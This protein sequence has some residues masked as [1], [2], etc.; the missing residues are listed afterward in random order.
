MTKKKVNLNEPL[1]DVVPFTEGVQVTYNHN[2]IVQDSDTSEYAL[3]TKNKVLMGN[4][5]IA[6]KKP[7]APIVGALINLTDTA[8]IEHNIVS[9]FN[10]SVLSESDSGYIKGNF[11]DGKRIIPNKSDEQYSI[12]FDIQ[13]ESDALDITI[14]NGNATYNTRERKYE[15]SL[16]SVNYPNS[17]DVTIEATR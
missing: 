14:T 1:R 5:D 2:I 3:L 16:T 11:A 12:M 17:I 4:V 6:Y 10:N 13:C 15:C 9:G 8:E 7:E